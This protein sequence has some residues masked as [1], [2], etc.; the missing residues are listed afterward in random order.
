[1]SWDQPCVLVVHVHVPHFTTVGGNEHVLVVVEALGA[2]HLVV[3]AD[4][5]PDLREIVSV[6]LEDVVFCSDSNQPPV[7][8]H[9]HI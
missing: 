8:L 5:T 1:V 3:E 4:Q 6:E 2:D 7:F 9:S